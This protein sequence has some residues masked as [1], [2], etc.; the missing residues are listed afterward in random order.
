M[1][2]FILFFAVMAAAWSVH[3]QD[4]IVGKWKTI[5]DETGEAK[6]IIEIY[7]QDGKY[8]GKIV[9]LLSEKNKDGIC[10]TCEGK[11]ANKNIIG[12]VI[13]KDLE[14][15]ADDKEWEGG[16]ILDPKT[17]KEYSVYL[18]LESPD[19]LKVR[20]YI[21]FSLIGRTQYWYRVK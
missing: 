1:K 5:D 7:K 21:G 17:G 13:L 18:K 14:Y 10:R 12:L 16:T 8:Y 19:K 4:E 20:G 3:A 15:D 2:K 6:S 11:F 9:K